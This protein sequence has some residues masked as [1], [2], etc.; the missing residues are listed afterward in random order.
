MSKVLTH[1]GHLE[2]ARLLSAHAKLRGAQPRVHPNGFIQ[3]DLEAPTDERWHEGKGA[4]TSGADLRLHIWNPRDHALPH[5]G[6]VNEIHDHVFDMKSAVVRGTLTQR[7]FEFVVG[8]MISQSAR[9]NPTHELYRAVYDKQSS[10]RLESLGVIGN[11]RKIQEF[12]VYAGQDYKQPAFTLHDT[13]EGDELVVTLMR[14][15]AIHEGIPVVVCPVGQP[16]DN[17]FDRATAAPQDYLWSAIE[18]SLS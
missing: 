17:D 16:P 7:V 9:A 11:L 2:T 8:A 12:P 6:T 10:S 3:L 4:G 13:V 1:P 5:Q 18:A 14:K 15:V